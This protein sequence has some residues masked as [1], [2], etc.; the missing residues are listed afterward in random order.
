[1]KAITI[2][3]GGQTRLAASIAAELHEMGHTVRIADDQPG[4]LRDAANA[5]GLT[6]LS[7]SDAT[8]A[9]WTLLCAQARGGSSDT[10][11][12]AAQGRVLRVAVLA[13]HMP[14]QRVR[15]EWHVPAG[16]GEWG[17]AASR[18]VEIDALLCGADL[19]HAIEQCARQL[20][21]DVVN[22]IA[23]DLFIDGAHCLVESD[24]L[25]PV[26][27]DALAH[28]HASNDTQRDFACEPS[29]PEMV[30]GAAQANP[31]AIALI[32]T[33]GPLDYERL[34]HS[35]QQFAQALH[36][37]SNGAND[38]P[39]AAVAV[40]LP[41]S[42]ALY[43]TMLGILGAGAV[44]VPL[45]PTFP[46]ERTRLI[47]Q[48][49]GAQNLV[50]DASFDTAILAGTGIRLIAAPDPR[51]THIAALTKWP[52][53]ADHDRSSRC[54][55][56]IYTSGS[57]GVPKGV[58][59]SHR[60]LVHFCHWYREHVALD[61]SARSLQFSTIAFDASLL[62]IFPTWLA[63]ATL[64]VPTE[65]QRHELD[66]LQSLIDRQRVTHAFLP[67]ALLAA[68][69]DSAL[70]SLR[71]LVTGGDVCD[72]DTIAR[73]SV[74]RHFHNIY[75]PTECTVLAT[76]SRLNARDNNRRIGRPIANVRCHVLDDNGYPVRTDEAGEL[77]IAGAGVGL[78]YLGQ[79]EL[80]A[81][82]FVVEPASKSA[83][84]RTGDIVQ[85]DA[86]GNLLYVGR[87]DKQIK[88]R[89]FR[90]E[91]GEVESA[92]LDTGLYRHCAAIADERK[93]IRVFV[94]KGT[95]ATATIDA[96]RAAL[97]QTLP[98]YMMPF[99]IAEL[100]LL[101]ATSNGK[102]DRAALARVPL[103]HA[104]A[105]MGEDQEP[106]TPTER[107]LRNLWA[108]LLDLDPAEIGRQ[109]S[110][111]ELGGHS[112]LVSRLML[113]VKR[114]LAGN[115]P[116][117]RF[118]EQP[119]IEAL[120][121][122]L[123]DDTLQRSERIPARV[124]EDRRLP[125]DIQPQS[126]RDPSAGPGAVLLTGA[127]GFLGT[128]ILQELIAKTDG[129]V[130][131]I[132]RAK[133]DAEARHRL[134][135][136]VIVNGMEQLCGHPRIRVLRG[137]LAQ[138]R[139]G[140]EETG[141]R[142]I[143]DDVDVIYHNGAHVNHVYDYPFLYDENVGSTIALLRLAC[144]GRRKSLHYVSTLSA[145]SAIDTTGNVLEAPPGSNPPVFVNNGYN[146]TKW[147]SEHLV[148]D[149]VRRGIDATILRPGNI[150]GHAQSGRCQP[151]RN[152]ILLLVKGSVQ[153]GF[154]PGG[155]AQF[156]LSPV[157]FLARAIVG[158]TLDRLRSTRVFHLHNPRPLTWNGYLQALACVGYDLTV[159]DS[160][161]WRER[162]LLIDEAN[163]LFD[164]VAFYLDDRQDDIGDMSV[165]D[166]AKSAATLARLGI[167]YPE[168]DERLLGQHFRYLIDC[169]FL[170]APTL[171]RPPAQRSPRTADPH[172]AEPAW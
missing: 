166:H 41:K 148:W 162:L 98:D 132:V 57:T 108:Q 56:A 33:E 141:W 94:A 107:H 13:D 12:Y 101:P 19:V 104:S 17:V 15:V 30:T 74:G 153:L 81:E 118:M 126:T 168:K 111:F 87:R 106:R 122:L 171:T 72:P 142:R 137:D 109:R 54:A 39:P 77:H 165:I 22:D 115:A 169:G 78:G 47:L 38:S 172:D 124:H 1:M 114:E 92:V 138:P 68:L 129:L 83:M 43:V 32:D 71:H 7:G 164:V 14:P 23:R 139:L 34:L 127:N 46:P 80:S 116:L 160:A 85:W 48:E 149:A 170:P 152:R 76:T 16:G 155:D 20:L 52:I 135:E 105:T 130:Y 95:Q 51:G 62:D 143:A 88:I 53:T 42:A 89:G 63:G 50:A 145:A 6:M 84:Y 49:S 55:I 161:S 40:C 61:A 9:V 79:P 167:A 120:A 100:E 157:D 21:T 31:N 133:S 125:D 67:P 73:W 119:T 97:G 117:G 91:L 60:N 3:I 147:V 134:D 154:A 44:C 27:L 131:C 59:L 28:W 37:D 64:V 29:L 45:D 26:D 69:P 159:E 99:D 25:V 18:V 66:S 82:R 36:A 110:F 150:T 35:A 146:L 10:P 70:P 65:T 75:G 156:D 136:A 90:V 4:P 151:G 144:E 5:L 123:T 93:R 121:S 103:S 86:D 58:M 8:A 96:L 113:A 128:F 24:D 102:I 2:A 140:L 158:C 112:L 163:A 11:S